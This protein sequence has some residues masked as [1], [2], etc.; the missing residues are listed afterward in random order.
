MSSTNNIWAGLSTTGGMTRSNIEV[1]EDTTCS[2]CKDVIPTG[3]K[4]VRITY[5]PT[6]SYGSG[7]TMCVC[8]K[9][10]KAMD[11]VMRTH[12]R[13]QSLTSPSAG[14]SPQFDSAQ[15]QEKSA[16][17]KKVEEFIKDADDVL[18]EWMGTLGKSAQV[19][20]DM[21]VKQKIASI[22]SVNEYLDYRKQHRYN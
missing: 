1:K 15:H 19:Y 3:G 21:D 18:D 14:I 6:D 16:S 2:V 17:E 13:I 11:L 9:C 8:E 20:K 10:M 4:A 22:I 7:E 12:R 5:I